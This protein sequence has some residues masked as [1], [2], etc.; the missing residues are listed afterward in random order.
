MLYTMLPLLFV[1]YHLYNQESIPR[2]NRRWQFRDERKA[3]A[4]TVES[5]VESV[6]CGDDHF[7]SV[8]YLLQCFFP[9]LALLSINGWGWLR[10]GNDWT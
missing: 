6:R 2:R 10:L 7:S 4:V 3:A 1:A 5:C 9:T 8:F